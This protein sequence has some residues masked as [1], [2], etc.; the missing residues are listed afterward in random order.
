MLPDPF[1]S[2]LFFGGGEHV[3]NVPPTNLTKYESQQSIFTLKNM[4]G[5][6]L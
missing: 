6:G 3:M 2:V 4:P 1:H 5:A